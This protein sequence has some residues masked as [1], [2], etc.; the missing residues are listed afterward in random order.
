M[1][2]ATG[3]RARFDV[4]VVGAGP[5]GSAAARWLALRGASVALM[6]RTGFEGTR[7][8]ESL[9][10]AVQPWIVKLG[11]WR[12]FLELGPVRSLGTRSRWGGDP[13]L[14]HSHLLS[15]WGCGWHVDRRALDRMFAEGACRA[16]AVPFFGTTVTGCDPEPNGWRLSLREGEGA[17]AR[18]LR[19]VSARVLVDATGRAARCASRLGARRLMLDRLVAIS[20]RFAG[21]EADRECH[22]LVEA[23]PDGWWYSAPV[24]GGGMVAMLMTDSDL[25][26][27]RGAVSKEGWESLLAVA[28]LTRARVERA[29]AVTAPIVY[30]AASQR[31]CRAK[32]RQ[33]WI[34]VGDAAL[35]VDPISG[36]GVIRALQT[37]WHGAE[38][39]SALLGARNAHAIATY[40]TGRD[41]ECTRYLEERAL[42]YAQESRWPRAP[43]WARRS[44]GRDNGARGG[45]I[46]PVPSRALAL[47]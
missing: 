5:A 2:V 18:A 45:P 28:S 34:A 40:E 16:G 46:Y 32:D 47:A 35:A 30:S 23:V 42:Y 31:L 17:S 22:V 1:T 33:P 44:V 14:V 25:C 8:G 38:S 29:H 26:R 4:A 37:A 15:P 6:E 11:L 7:V 41:L 10:P 24:P 21:I 12:E 39:A 9:A 20:V 13:V 36:S 19:T 3:A 27:R 43:F